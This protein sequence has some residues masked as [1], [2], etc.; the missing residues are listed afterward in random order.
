MSV[1]VL[2]HF[3]KIANNGNISFYHKELWDEQRLSLIGK[4][5]EITI[6]ERH[7]KPSI[8]QFSY[9]WGGILRTCLQHESF[10][11]YTSVEELHKEVMQPLF[12]G[13]QVRVVVGGKK[14]DKHMVKS[15]TELN[16]E[17]TSKF[18]E[19]VLN[20]VAQEGVIILQPEQY[21]EK[22]YKEI[23]LDKE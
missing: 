2:K 4:E 1:L 18:I 20:F 22:Y 13:Y 7:R 5:V 10:S 14:Y 15:L 19:N 12:L 21:Q 16:K 6:K 11:H 17:E 3:A 9:Y 23:N 8:S